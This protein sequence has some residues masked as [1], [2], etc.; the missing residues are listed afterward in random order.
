MPDPELVEQI[1]SYSSFSH[2]LKKSVEY[3]FSAIEQYDA[4]IR[5]LTT[6]KDELSDLAAQADLLA[7]HT[8]I[9]ATHMNEESQ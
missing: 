5:K 9:E 2:I 7:L 8:T 6:Q 4:Q 1:S 3:A